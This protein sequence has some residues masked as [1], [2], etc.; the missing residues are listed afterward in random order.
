MSTTWP[1]KVGTTYEQSGIVVDQSRID[2]YAKASG[3]FNPLHVDPAFAAGTAFGGT[4][5]HGLLTLAFV[6]SLLDRSSER[7]WSRG[8]G[9]LDVA[10]IGPVRPGDT[11]DVRATTTDGGVSEQ[12]T[13]PASGLGSSDDGPRVAPAAT[14]S[15]EVRAGDRLVL[16]GTARIPLADRDR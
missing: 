2:A 16:A 3:D 15:V 8:G 9:E 12:P 10:F 11:L 13:A 1:P 5:A 14:F 4:I 6:N 7:R